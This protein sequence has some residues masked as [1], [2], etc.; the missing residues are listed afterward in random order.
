V[1]QAIGNALCITGDAVSVKQSTDKPQG[2][3][4]STSGREPMT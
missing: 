3:F 2:E 1:A 4:G